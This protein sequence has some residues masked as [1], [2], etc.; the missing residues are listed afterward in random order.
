M[1]GKALTAYLVYYVS[2]SLAAGFLTAMVQVILELKL[3]DMFQKHIQ[4]LTGIPL[5]TVT[6]FMTSAAVLLLPFNMI[7]DKIPALNK[8]ADTN[9]LKKKIGIFSENSVMGFIIGLGLGFAAAYG[10][11][12]SLNLAI[13]TATALSLFPMISKMFMQ[14]LSPLADAMSEFMKK[15]FKDREVYIGLDWPILAGRSEIWVTAILLVP[16]FIGYA[17]ILPGNQVLPLAGIINYSIAVGGL[18]LTGGNLARMLILGI[19]TMPIYLYGATY[20]APILSDLA[21]KSGAV[22][23]IKKGQLITWS[24]IE[25][26]E[27]RVLFAEAF[28]RNI[29]AIVGC[30][31]FLGLFVLLYKY[32]IKAKV[33]SERYAELQK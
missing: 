16:V 10:V 19:I 9:A 3:G 27:F 14:S 25:G 6:H 15:R 8:R 30:V 32:M 28:N 24:S 29:L 2:G 5:V 1:F 20:L 22:E 13:Q 11:S 33:P 12:G 4:D 7:M 17:I 26:P 31:I 23:G 18:L 21:E